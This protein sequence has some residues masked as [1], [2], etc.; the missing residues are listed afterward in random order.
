M[1]LGKPKAIRI[2]WSML[3]KMMT[4]V[5]VNHKSRQQANEDALKN[6]WFRGTQ[7]NVSALIVSSVELLKVYLKRLLFFSAGFQCGI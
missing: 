1:R 2:N 4:R 5:E 3:K 6:L 7:G